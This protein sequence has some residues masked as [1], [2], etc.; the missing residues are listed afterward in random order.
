MRI[1]GTDILTFLAILISGNFSN[2]KT[3]QIKLPNFKG[4]KLILFNFSRVRKARKIEIR[5]F[6]HNHFQI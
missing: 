4:F 3:V 1:Q 6:D 5:R 2:M